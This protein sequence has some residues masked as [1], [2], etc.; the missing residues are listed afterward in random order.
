MGGMRYSRLFLR[1]VGDHFHV[2]S[3]IVGR[4]FLLGEEEKRVFHGIMRRLERH[5]G[6]Q[7]LTYCLM[8]NHVHLLLRTEEIDGESM[9]DG[10]LI[11]RVGGMYSRALGRELEWQLAT[12]REKK[13][14]NMIRFWREKYL[15]RLGNLS[16]FMWLLKNRFSKWYNAE[17]DRHGTLWEDRY[18]VVLVQ[19]SEAVLVK[20]GAYIDLNPVRAG[21]VE[22]PAEYGWSGYGEASGIGKRKQRQSQQQKQKGS[23]KTAARTGSTSAA[24]SAASVAAARAGIGRIT[25]AGSGPGRG[26]KEAG[27][28]YRMVLFSEGVERT[29]GAKVEVVRDRSGKE[30]KRKAISTEAAEKVVKQRGEVDRHDRRER[31]LDRVREFTEGVIVGSR[32]FVDRI[33]AQQPAEVRGK[34]KTGARKMRGDEWGVSGGLFA[35]REL[36]TK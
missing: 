22:D 6:V 28:M 4:E 23:M 7:V 26:W 2:V 20:I 25:G 13:N 36:R 15:A 1:A 29:P 12:W 5:A 34:R 31:L 32:E 11:G 16:E 17:N 30:V 19:D 18:K 3:R 9:S 24:T 8:D 14:E 33:F 10:E 35:L 21:M 27:P